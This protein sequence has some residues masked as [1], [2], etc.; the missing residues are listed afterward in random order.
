MKLQ[1]KVVDFKFFNR[2]QFFSKFSVISS[3]EKTYVYTSTTLTGFNLFYQNLI[4]QKFDLSKSISSRNPD[5]IKIILS[6]QF[7][8]YLQ[9]QV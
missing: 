1:K 3:Y 5:Q 7:T 8:E 6:S 4:S 9:H 2:H